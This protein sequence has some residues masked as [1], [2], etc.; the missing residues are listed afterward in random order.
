MWSLVE[1]RI[2]G[3]RACICWIRCLDVVKRRTFRTS[4]ESAAEQNKM[5]QATQEKQTQIKNNRKT[6]R[7]VSTLNYIA[8]PEK[9]NRNHSP[10]RSNQATDRHDIPREKDQIS[11]ITDRRTGVGKG[12]ALAGG[13]YWSLSSSATR[14]RSSS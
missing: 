1:N 5:S 13:A 2:P 4:T 9:N 11:L 7:K 6:N 8:A 10:E 12:S 14:S 3:Q